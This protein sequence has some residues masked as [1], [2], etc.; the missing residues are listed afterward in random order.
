MEQFSKILY[1]SDKN[2]YKGKVTYQNMDQTFH[3]I[4]YI[5]KFNMCKIQ[6]YMYG[7]E[8]IVMYTFRHT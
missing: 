6:Q 4:G 3:T 8:T 1:R 2:G 5:T 7:Y